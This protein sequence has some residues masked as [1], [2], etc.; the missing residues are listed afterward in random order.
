M[1]KLNQFFRA[2]RSYS[3]VGL[4]F[5]ISLKARG[6][7]IL[8][9]GTCRACGSCCMRISLEGPGG[10]LRSEKIFIEM[11]KRNPPLR[12]F[13]ILGRDSQGFLIFSCN[14]SSNDGLCKDYENRLDLCKNFPDKSLLF[15]GGKLPDGCGYSFS[16][17]TSFEKILSQTLAD[18]PVRDKKSPARQ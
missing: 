11:V 6:K 1:G 17:V 14:W 10:W 3:L 8:I 15:S 5:A 13:E 2:A 16:Q 18:K 12:R 9:T 7:K 4:L